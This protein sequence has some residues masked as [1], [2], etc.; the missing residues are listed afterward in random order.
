VPK[1]T[2]GRLTRLG[3]PEKSEKIIFAVTPEQKREIRAMAAAIKEVTVTDYLLEL[4]RYSIRQLSP[5]ERARLKNWRGLLPPK[6][7]KS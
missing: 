2:K 3:L 6:G 5:E 7:G 1:K 4:H